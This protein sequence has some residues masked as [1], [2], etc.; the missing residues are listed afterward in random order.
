[1]ADDSILSVHAIGFSIELF[2]LKRRPSVAIGSALAEHWLPPIGD[3]DPQRIGRGAKS[4]ASLTSHLKLSS[5]VL[6]FF[7]FLGSQST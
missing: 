1:M 5:V 6:S 7:L 3:P 4:S 2:L